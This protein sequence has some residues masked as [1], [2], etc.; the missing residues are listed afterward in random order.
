[1]PTLRSAGRSKREPR[2][3]HLNK[4]VNNELR[5][6][7][8]FESNSS[9]NPTTEKSQQRG[10]LVHQTHNPELKMVTD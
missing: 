7:K 6:L 5:Y 10:R 8:Q 2:L 9:S 4:R 1:V 3:K